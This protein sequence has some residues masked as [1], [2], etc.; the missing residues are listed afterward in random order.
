MKASDQRH[1][2]LHWPIEHRQSHGLKQTSMGMKERSEWLSVMNTSLIMRNQRGGCLRTMGFTSTSMAIKGHEVVPHVKE[3]SQLKESM[4]KTHLEVR[5]FNCLNK[6][7]QSMLT[8]QQK[9]PNSAVIHLGGGSGY[10]SIHQEF[11]S[12]G[13][14]LSQREPHPMA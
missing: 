12:N 11:A 5:V 6:V 3:L 9:C 14:S 10:R 2:R 7:R 1:A 4:I 8:P 13:R